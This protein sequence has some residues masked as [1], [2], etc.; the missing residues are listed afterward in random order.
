MCTFTYCRYWGRRITNS[1]H[2]WTIYRVK[3]KFVF[4]SLMKLCKN[5][6]LKEVG[7]HT[8]MLALWVPSFIPSTTIYTE[9][10]IFLIVGESRRQSQGD[11]IV[12][13]S[14]GLFFPL[15]TYTGTL[16]SHILH[17]L[18]LGQGASP[19]CLMSICTYP[20][21]AGSHPCEFCDFNYFQG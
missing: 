16:C 6:K 10:Q 21:R 14:E 8:V 7:I 19:D 5:R 1:R 18:A 20:Y 13:S 12:G 4:S 9:N 17:A 2:A 3:F 15:K 11:N